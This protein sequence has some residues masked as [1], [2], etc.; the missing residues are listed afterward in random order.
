MTRPV[1][2][3]VLL[4]FAALNSAN[5]QSTNSNRSYEWTAGGGLWGSLL[6]SYELGATPAGSPAYRDSLNNLGGITQMKVVRRWLWTRT[7]FE[8]KGFFAASDST[9]SSGMVD[10]DVPDPITGAIS[11]LTGGQPYLKSKAQNYG[12]DIGLR[13]TWRTRFGGL[14]AGA[15]FS[16]MRLDQKFDVNYSATDLFREDLDSEF[17]GG[18]AVFG[19]DG[20]IKGCPTNLD[21]QIGFYDLNTDYRVVGQATPGQSRT[22]WQRN[23]TTIET[24]ITA[25]KCVYDVEVIGTLGVMYITDMPAIAHNVGA[26]ASIFSDDAVTITGAVEVLLW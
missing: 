25:R 21:L 18:K 9:A 17:R 12:G 14:S 16:Y 24:S 2:I 26:P 19:W 8:A 5:A 6:P 3:A 7:N 1:C 23:S 22:R 4:V 20:Y 10:A 13:D 11:N 15:L